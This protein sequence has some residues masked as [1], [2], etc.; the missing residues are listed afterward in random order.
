MQL[1]N[2]V[3]GFQNSWLT[4]TVFLAFTIHQQ[5]TGAI[6]NDICSVTILSLL[7]NDLPW[8]V[9]YTACAA[10]TVSVQ[11][12]Q[13]SAGL[14]SSQDQQVRVGYILIKTMSLSFDSGGSFSQKPCNKG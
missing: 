8:L 1:A 2:R 4:C 14:S 13:T 3:C 6:H 5:I 12:R 11:D 7:C 10:Q 9:C